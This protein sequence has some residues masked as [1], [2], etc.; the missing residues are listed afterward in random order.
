M[1]IVVSLSFI[2]S[3]NLLKFLT[4]TFIL[5]RVEEEAAIFLELAIASFTLLGVKVALLFNSIIRY[6]S[7]LIY[8]L[9]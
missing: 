9:S 5:L 8:F 1:L 7:I 2:F 4:S 6:I 3:K